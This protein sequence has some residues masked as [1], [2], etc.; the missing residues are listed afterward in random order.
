MAEELRALIPEQKRFFDENGY[1][2]IRQLHSP[3]E[4][5]E[6]RREMNRLLREPEQA[7]PRVR[8]SYEPPEDAARYPVDPDNPRRAWMIMDTPL[9]GDWWFRQ[10]QDPRVVDII[11][12]CLGPNVDFH[13]GK[14]RIKPPGYRTHQVWHQ[15]WPY[16]RHTRPE[17][18]AAITYLDNTWEGA[19]TTAVVPGSHLRG[20]WPHDEKNAIPD[21]AV[22]GAG[23]P[24]CARAG[25]VVIV[26]VL[27]VHKAGANET[28][29]N[30][31][32]IINEYKTHEAVDQWGNPCAFADMPLRRNRLPFR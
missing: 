16:E 18:A 10:F 8:F 17:L 13:N 21:A 19:A 1:L 2:L 29:Q 20:E 26:H 31:S 25:D 9:A 12:D 14:A 4:V 7:H 6:A 30:R 5:A 15:D 3:E 27:L 28:A 11:S 32:C 24:V 22:G 23:V